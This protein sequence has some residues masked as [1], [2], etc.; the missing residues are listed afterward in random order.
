M[1]LQQYILN[2]GRSASISLDNAKEKLHKNCS[3]ALKAWRKNGGYIYRGVRG[4]KNE[5]AYMD[6]TKYDERAS[7][8]TTNEY[9]VL[10]N[11][12]LDSWKQYPKRNVI[13]ITENVFASG[14]GATYHIFPYNGTKIGICSGFDIWESFKSF[15]ELIDLNDFIIDTYGNYSSVKELEKWLKETKIGDLDEQI[16][17]DSNY[18]GF[19]NYNFDM[20]LY[21]LFN[22]IILNPVR[23]GFKLVKVGQNIPKDREVWFDGK[24]VMVIYWPK[25]IIQELL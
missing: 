3:D 4:M 19:L 14:H 16:L 11:H 24:A 17:D 21:D 8:N 6:S 10:I 23:N 1:R 13:C 12:I 20:T 5:Y 22:K 7:A 9:T 18:E 15:E 2:E 25:D